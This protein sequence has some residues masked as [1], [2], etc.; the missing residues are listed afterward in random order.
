MPFASKFFSTVIVYTHVQ[1]CREDLCIICTELGKQG[2]LLTAIQ[3][4]MIHWPLLSKGQKEGHNLAF[5]SSTRKAK[6]Y[7]QSS[8]NSSPLSW[9]G[10]DLSSALFN[11]K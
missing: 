2:M 7:Q 11:H 9:Q 5:S 8:I 1:R 3:Q 6:P 4:K 10:E